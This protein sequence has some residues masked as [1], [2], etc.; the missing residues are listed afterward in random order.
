MNCKSKVSIKLIIDFMC[1]VFGFYEC[2]PRHSG[3]LFRVNDMLLERFQ[4]MKQ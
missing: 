4:F 1:L 2:A 3:R